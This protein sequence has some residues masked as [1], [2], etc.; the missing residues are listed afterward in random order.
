MAFNFILRS[1]ITRIYRA[2]IPKVELTKHGK[3]VLKNFLFGIAGLSGNYTMED[4]EMIAIEY[5]KSTVKD[6]KALV[7]C[8]GG[9]DSTVCVALV[10]KALGAEKVYSLH[11]DNGSCLVEDFSDLFKGFMRKNESNKVK[12]ALENIGL[13][14]HV[15]DASEAFYHATTLLKDGTRTKPLNQTV[16]PEEKRKIIGD[17][18][19]TV[20]EE[21]VKKLHLQPS[22]IFLA[23]GTLRPGIPLMKL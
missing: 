9:V 22:E 19:M 11:I 1:N 20:A 13:K 18:F 12:E 14:L 4:R 5:I 3:E 6:K 23:Q 17:A 15:V 8:S 7:L 16:N 10:E 2:D 21:E